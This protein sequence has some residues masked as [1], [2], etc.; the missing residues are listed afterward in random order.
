MSMMM[1]FTILIDLI[2]IYTQSW[3]WNSEIALPSITAEGIGHWS[4]SD[5]GS[6]YLLPIPPSLNGEFASLE[7]VFKSELITKLST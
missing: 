1:I 6:E 5:S 7:T 2:L 3:H 4:V